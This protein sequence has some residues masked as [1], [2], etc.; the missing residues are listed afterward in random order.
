MS[1]FVV[2]AR[3]QVCLGVFGYAALKRHWPACEAAEATRRIKAVI[4]NRLAS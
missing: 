1:R 4:D 2:K 3:C